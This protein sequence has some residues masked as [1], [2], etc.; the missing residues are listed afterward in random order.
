MQPRSSAA[1]ATV[2]ARLA[3]AG[4]VA[5]EEEAAE[6]VTNAPDAATLDD[7]V[8]RREQ[9]EPLAWITGFVDFC[10][11]RV[12]VDRGVYVPRQ[13]TEELARRAAGLLSAHGGRAA[14]LCTGA[15]AVAAHIAAA[16]G[17]P[18]VGTDTD[19]LAVS[20][21]RRNGVRA[22]QGDLGA[23]LGGGTFSVVTAVAPYVPTQELVFLPAD[24]R[25][26]EPGAALDGGAD[27]LDVVRRVVSD[28]ARLLQARGWLLLEVG[29]AQDETLVPYLAACGFATA[30]MWCDADGDLR[31]LMA[32][33]R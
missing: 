19:V 6:L 9:G 28:A 22:A 30:E 2:T 11:R 15:G 24:V 32:R 25:R 14:D 29:G 20:C 12:G 31:G 16:T 1:V 23:P 27:G 3:V 10:G 8:A 7:W 13:Q 18:V 4:C 5:A 17:T 26:Y 21:A 33:V